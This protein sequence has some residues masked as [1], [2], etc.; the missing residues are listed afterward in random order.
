MGYVQYQPY[1]W[2]FKRYIYVEGYSVDPPIF[3]TELLC[4]KHREEAQECA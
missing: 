4:R 2:E 1:K 3:L